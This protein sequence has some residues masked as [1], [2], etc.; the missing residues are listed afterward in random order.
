M[1]A[2][3]YLKK[4]SQ[5]KTVLD[6]GRIESDKVF[7]DAIKVCDIYKVR[8]MTKD[9]RKEREPGAPDVILVRA[10]GGKTIVSRQ[11]LVNNFTTAAGKPVKVAFL[12]SK[13]SYYVYR[14]CN[15][16]YKVMHIPNN[17]TVN[18]RDKPVNGGN[19]IICQV[20]KDG[21][22]LKNTMVQ[23]NGKLFRKMFKVPLQS[24]IRNHWG[25]HNKNINYDKISRDREIRMN[26]PSG[27]IHNRNDVTTIVSNGG[28]VQRPSA[29]VSPQRSAQGIQVSNRPMLNKQAKPN[30]AQVHETA[31]QRNVEQHVEDKYR[32]RVTKRIV[33][34][35]SHKLV[36][37][38]VMEIKTGKEKPVGLGNVRRMCEL[39]SVENL[40]LVQKE[41]SSVTYLRGNGVRL[42]SLPEIIS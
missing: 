24:V 9:E 23:L 16:K 33:S 39:K 34:M 3:Q 1:S 21:K 22:M 28:G 2:P 40:M 32:Y 15:E 20:G 13:K 29:S 4:V 8:L 38:V 5:G 18:L 6:A 19:Y 42:E 27:I 12:R 14:M 36:G 37:F 7:I 10:T 31:Q 17:C 26:N 25:S 35:D 11:D 30:N 41:N